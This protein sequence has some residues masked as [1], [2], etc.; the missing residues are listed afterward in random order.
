MRERGENGLLVPW[1]GLSVFVNPPWSR[2]KPF[3]LKAWEADSFC[4]LVLED[5]STKWWEILTQ[6][7][8]FRFSFN[9]RIPFDAPPGV[10]T[11]SNDRP[12]CMIA[13]PKMRAAIGNAF[14]KLG[15]WWKSD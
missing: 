3:A 6:F 15:R 10:D 7:P 4:F 13:D 8:C 11:S 14:D 2:I 12:T 9:E 5:A 1:D